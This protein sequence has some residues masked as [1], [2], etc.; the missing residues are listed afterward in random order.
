LCDEWRSELWT[1]LILF[2]IIIKSI[3]QTD[4]IEGLDLKQLGNEIYLFEATEKPWKEAKSYCEERGLKLAILESQEEAELIWEFRPK[5][6]AILN[7][8]L[9]TIFQKIVFFQYLFGSEC[10]EQSGKS[11]LSTGT[12]REMR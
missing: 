7:L 6:G 1:P 8:K 9:A 5:N 11:Q 2:K 4:K 10:L 3:F 12:I